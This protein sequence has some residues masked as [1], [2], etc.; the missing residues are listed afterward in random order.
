LRLDGARAGVACIRQAGRPH[1]RGVDQTDCPERLRRDVS[2]WLIAG[3]VA[4][5]LI[6]GGLDRRLH[7]R[8]EMGNSF[9]SQ[10]V[11]RETIHTVSLVAPHLDRGMSVLDVGCGEGF[12]GEELASRGV[13]EVY[14]VDIVDVRAAKGIPFSYYDGR[15][16]PFPDERFDMV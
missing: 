12:V 8:G 7:R 1:A 9:R 14:G 16:L 11:R 5:V 10:V 2:T 4:P 15:H 3:R 6:D 13:R